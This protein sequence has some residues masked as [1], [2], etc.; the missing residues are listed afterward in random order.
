MR[1]LRIRP[2][3][4]AMISCS[5]SSFTL[6]VAFGRSSVTTPGNSS[7]SS[8]AIRLLPHRKLRQNGREAAQN[9]AGLLGPA[10]PLFRAKVAYQRPHA[11]FAADAVDIVAGGD[12]DLGEHGCGG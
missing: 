8:F 4:W 3:V 7:I 9:Q 6:K 12:V 10:K 2:A 1:F 11:G 5:F